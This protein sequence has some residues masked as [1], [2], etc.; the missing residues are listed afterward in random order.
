MPKGVEGWLLYFM[1]AWTYI[2]LCSDGSY[3]AGSTTNLEQR[4][5]DHNNGRY[6]GYTSMRLPVRLGWYQEFT[7][8]RDAIILERQI[9]GWSRKKKEALIRGDFH[10]LHELARS[11]K[12]K[13]RLMS[14]PE[15]TSITSESKG[16][17]PS[18]QS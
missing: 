17:R 7:D 6:G 15:R 4:I 18:T 13:N 5:V 16:E 11:T 3:Y 1:E 12:T 8:A 9:K 2:L 10:M 14:H